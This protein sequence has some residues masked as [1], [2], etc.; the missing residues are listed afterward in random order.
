VDLSACVKIRTT[1]VRVRSLAVAVAVLAASATASAQTVADLRHLSIEQLTDLE[2]TSVSRRPEPLSDAPAAVFVIT[3]DEIRRSGAVT[4][5][6]ALRLAPNLE[7]AQQDALNYAISARGFNSIDAANK[8]LVLIDGRS[9]YSPLHGGVF[10]DQQQVALENVERIEVISG[11]GGTL[12]GANAFN[13]VINVITKNAHETQGGLLDLKAGNVYRN[14]VEQYGARFGA[15]GAYR[16]YGMGFGYGHSDTSSGASAGDQWHGGQTGF[17]TDW[18]SGSDSLTMEGDFYRS[19]GALLDTRL[20]GENVLGRW[21]HRFAG[22][23]NLQVQSYY[24]NQKTSAVGIS[25]AVTTLDLQAQDTMPLGRSEVVWGGGYRVYLDSFS[26]TQNAFRLVPSHRT[27]GIG[28]LFAQDTIALFG[29]LKLTLGLKLEDSS[30]TG[31]EVLP[32]IRLGWRVSDKTF[33]WAAVSRAVRTP[34]RI[35]REL[36]APGALA[37][38]LDFL[39]EEVT[40]YEI[41]Y[42]GRPTPDTSLSVSF[43]YNIYGDLR[44]YDAYPF[45]GAQ[46][47]IGNGGSGTGYGMEAWGA[48]QALPWWRLSAGVNLLRKNITFH[49]GALVAA[50]NALTVGYDPGYQLSLRSSMNLSKTVELDFGVRAVDALPGIP[51]PAYVAGDAR[52]GWHVTPSLELSLAGSDLSFRRHAETVTPPTPIVEPRQSVYLGMRW[53]Y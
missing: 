20:S 8:L 26:N 32:E 41:G 7:V 21:N 6:E 38:D 36:L 50:S 18:Q 40:A 47:Q 4:L 14:G 28:N 5:A 51:I 46:A 53:R 52:I 33:L 45:P 12:Y 9:V 37:P 34:S 2:I 24:D 16:V 44:S 43:Y 17:R 11:P 25:D 49:P 27:L 31:A 35:D 13:G 42:R 19:E 29:T 10:W 30:Y 3:S 15:N 39:S 48:W 22:G 1:C 23:S